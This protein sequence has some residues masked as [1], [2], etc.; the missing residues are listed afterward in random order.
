MWKKLA[1]LVSFLLLALVLFKVPVS[2][3][4]T[5]VADCEAYA[6]SDP[7]GIPPLSSVDINF[8]C[9]ASA[10]VLF[11]VCDSG[12]VPNDD[13][14]NIVYGGNIVTFNYYSGTSE[15]VVIGSAQ[16]SVGGNVATLNSVNNAAGATY[17]YALSTDQ[18]GVESYLE[19]NCG[20]DFAGIGSLGA[21][22]RFVPVF[23]TDKAPANGTLKFNVLFGEKNREEGITL[24]VWDITAGQQ[25]NNDMVIF[26]APNWGRLWWQADGE[27]TWYLLPSQYWQGDG[28]SA[29]EY[30]LSCDSGGVPSYHTSFAKA[31]PESQLPT[32]TP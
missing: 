11:G 13:L 32:F 20:V 14:F 6:T 23:T 22:D 3:Q 4:A 21:C 5:P 26:P 7:G 31:I 1:L 18:G 8:N 19:A 15:F 30:G 10:T 9:A 25:I 2:V 12:P 17:S 16:T 24:K 29:S 27:S 28:T